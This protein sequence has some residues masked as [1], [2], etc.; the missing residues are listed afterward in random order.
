[1]KIDA[2]LI[3]SAGYSA[4][5]LFINATVGDAASSWNPQ[6]RKIASTLNNRSIVRHGHEFFCEWPELQSRQENESHDAE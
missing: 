4:S 1:M 6:A 5:I 2:K 3:R